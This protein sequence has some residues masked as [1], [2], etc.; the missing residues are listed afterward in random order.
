MS[1]PPPLALR[2]PT[3]A[4]KAARPM[5]RSRANCATPDA[6]LDIDLLDHVIVAEPTTDPLGSGY[7]SFRE[8]GVL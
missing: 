4:A 3:L 6:S 8:E 1:A 2:F 7:Y 5:F